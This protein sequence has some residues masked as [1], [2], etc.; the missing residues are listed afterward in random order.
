MEDGKFIREILSHSDD[1]GYWVPLGDF[2]YQCVN[3]ECVARACVAGGNI[4]GESHGVTVDIIN[5]HGGRVDS[6]YLPFRCY[7]E[8][9]KCSENAPEW[10]QHVSHGKWWFS[11]RPHVLPKDSDYEKIAKAIRIYIA[12]FV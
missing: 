12:L 6:C 1:A 2:M 11:D 4:V 5:K 10:Y 8:P 3:C 9:V 7:F